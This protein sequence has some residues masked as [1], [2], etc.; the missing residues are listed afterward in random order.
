MIIFI[1][2][3]ILFVIVAGRL[4]SGFVYLALFALAACLLT[5]WTPLQVTLIS[6]I[7]WGC[8]ELILD[9][10]QQ[11]KSTRIGWISSSEGLLL[12]VKF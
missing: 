6:I 4:H 12:A 5:A 2:L 9:Y 1:A 3:S 7:T 8:T 10:W 11:W